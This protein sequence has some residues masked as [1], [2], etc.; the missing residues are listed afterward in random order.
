MN[1]LLVTSWEIPCG[2]AE[3]SAMLIDAVTHA[4]PDINIAPC[5]ELDPGQLSAMILGHSDIIHLNYQAALHS[6][7]TPAWIETFRHAGHKVVVTYHDTGVP[8]SDQCKAICAAA[9]EAI[10]HEPYDDLPADRTHYWRM[11]VLDLKPVSPRVPLTRSSTRPILG[12]VGFAFPWKCYDALVAAAAAAGWGVLLI[13]PHATPEQVDHWMNLNPYLFVTANFL[14]R[15]EAVAM[16]STCDA[17]AF[18]YV[19]HNTGQSGAI[20]LGIAARKP[21]FALST[22]RQFRALYHDPIAR[23]AIRWIENFDELVT[24][25]QVQPLT[26]EIDTPTAALAEQESWSALGKKYSALYKSLV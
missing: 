24:G 17:T 12:T 25:L 6:Q 1:V 14:P 20:L 13:A 3:H 18:T 9:N 7:W 2:I 26:G 5:S 8:N 23:M 19:T 10:V 22:C 21:V 15:E 11:G 4:D 16:L